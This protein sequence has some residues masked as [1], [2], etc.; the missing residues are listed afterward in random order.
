[1]IKSIKFTTLV[2]G[3]HLMEIGM[4]TTLFDFFVPNGVALRACRLVLTV[5][6]TD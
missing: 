2:F 4:T 6:N 1:V 3:T 5:R